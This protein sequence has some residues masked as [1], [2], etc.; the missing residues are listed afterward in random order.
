[1]VREVTSHK[2][3]GYRSVLLLGAAFGI[4]EEGIILKS[5]FDPTWMGAQITSKVL[6]VYGISVLQPFANVAYHAV[7]SITAPIMLIEST[8]SREPWLTKRGIVCAGAVF[9]VAAFFLQT[10][11]DYTIKGWQYLFAALF[12]V[13]FIILGLKNKIPS[14]TRMYSPGKIWTLG[15][16][17]VFLLFFIFYGLSNMGAPWYIILGL[18]LFMYSVYWRMI[19]RCMWERINLFAAGAGIVTGLLP[20][21][22]IVARAEPAKIGNFVGAIISALVLVTMYK[23][24][25]SESAV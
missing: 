21:V 9:V 18:A 6:R 16:L 17:F 7:V 10:F 22:A 23:N 20:I 25:R 1:M 15:F 11:N 3:L 24:L 4:L 13:L 12:L 19:S 2:N 8:A 5:W 14:T